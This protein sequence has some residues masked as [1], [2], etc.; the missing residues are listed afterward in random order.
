M[1]KRLSTNLTLATVAL[2]LN[3]AIGQEASYLTQKLM[4]ENDVR[5]KITEALSKII[6]EQKYVI[7]VSIDLELSSEVQEQITVAPG[8]E[9]TIGSQTRDLT[10]AIEDGTDQLE[11]G[12]G[13]S[14]YLPIPGFE[15][16]MSGSDDQETQPATEAV[17]EPAAAAAGN[18]DK[19]LSRVVTDKRLSVAHIRKMD[20]SLILQEGAAPE[21]IENI[22]QIVM[23]AS[24]FNRARGDALSIMTAT[25]KERRDQRSAET[26]LL[27]S[28]SDKVDAM[29]RQQEAKSVTAEKDW[30][31]ELENYKQEESDRREQD[32]SYFQ[33][34]LD[35][36][37]MAA[38]ARAFEQEKRDI[39]QRDSLQLI[40]MN[41]EI[42]NLR[43]QLGTQA[44]SD[45]E[46][47]AARSRVAQVEGERSA[48]DAQITEKISTLESVQAEL[49][50]IQGGMN[51]LPLYLMGVIS[52]LAVIALVIVL[53]LNN[54]NKPQYVPPPP[55]MMQPPPRR[56]KKKPRPKKEPEPAQ[57]AAAPA[58]ATPAQP[59][60]AAPPQPAV[61][62]DPGVVQ[63]EINDMR[64]AVVSMSVG[65][66]ETATH[67]V[68][69]WMQ[70]EAPAAPEEA[71]TET[72][73]EAEETKGKKKKK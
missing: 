12:G 71:E 27:K 20:I 73:A 26:I 24:R 54:R 46:A 29:E 19:V 48:L 61:G 44:L 22:R 59:Q 41:Q 50:K 39:L 3:S 55:W 6:D 31:Q 66:P 45:S 52:L 62:D 14:N 63:S 38:R 23:V 67:I 1:I 60:P 53:V 9:K 28:I 35:K 7:D 40:S 15:F 68:R 56:R 11:T 36:I 5:K 58:P 57:P 25:F 18:G 13:S 43:A 34:E 51:R 2:L 4:L 70:E 69:E 30:R 72:E 10:R 21:L 64:K 65:Q 32:R 17:P 33:S 49:D 16:E 47:I 37:E 8:A 42:Q